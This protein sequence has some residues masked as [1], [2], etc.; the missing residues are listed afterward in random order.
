[1]IEMTNNMRKIFAILYIFIAYLFGNNNDFLS[2]A[3]LAI[4]NKNYKEQL[5]IYK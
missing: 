4:K 1:M 3:T 5:C 2:K